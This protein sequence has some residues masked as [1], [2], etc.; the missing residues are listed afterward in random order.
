MSDARTALSPDGRPP[1]GATYDP[2]TGRTTFALWAPE[3]DEVE[4][5][6]FDDDRQRRVPLLERL[7]GI[8]FDTVPNTAPGQLYGFR[9]HGP[10]IPERGL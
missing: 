8:W 9:V 10:W 3:A 7:H 6:L 2:V 4:V 1:L 5:C